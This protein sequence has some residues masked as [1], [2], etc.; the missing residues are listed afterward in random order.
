MDFKLKPQDFEGSPV[1]SYFSGSK[2]ERTG[3][4]QTK[5]PWNLKGNSPCFI[6]KYFKQIWKFQSPET[7]GLRK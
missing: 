6:P 4:R 3:L 2:F 7:Y 5:I 1:D